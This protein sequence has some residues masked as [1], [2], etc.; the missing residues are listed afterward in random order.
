MKC[1]LLAI[2]GGHTEWGPDAAGATSD[3]SPQGDPGG[4]RRRPRLRL[5]AENPRDFGR[6]FLLK[7]L[8]CRADL[9]VT[10][11]PGTDGNHSCGCGDCGAGDEDTPA[12]FSFVDDA[13][14]HPAG[15]RHDL[16]RDMP[17]QFV[18]RQHDDLAGDILRLRDLP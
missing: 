16:A 10:P 15:D 11:W 2:F 7:E 13:A 6:L 17:R 5:T 12:L 18:R 14:L 9:Q 4:A 1:P 8:P 3:G